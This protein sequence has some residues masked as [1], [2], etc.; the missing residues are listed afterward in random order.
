MEAEIGIAVV[1][2]NGVVFLV[3]GQRGSTTIEFNPSVGTRIQ[4]IVHDT[5]PHLQTGHPFTDFGIGTKPNRIEGPQTVVKRLCAE[6]HCNRYPGPGFLFAG[7]GGGVAA[8][9]GVFGIVGVVGVVGV[10]GCVE[11]AGILV[12]V[13]YRTIMQL[14]LQPFTH[15]IIVRIVKRQPRPSHIVQRNVLGRITPQITRIPQVDHSVIFLC[16]FTQH[17]V[18]EVVRAPVIHYH[19]LPIGECLGLQGTDGVFNV[20]GAIVGGHYY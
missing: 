18:R 3:T 19:Q 1:F 4:I 6:E 15:R 20:F 14:F 12:M 2:T 8:I 11:V 9:V 7:K 17:C 10:V 16:Q 13:T 5:N